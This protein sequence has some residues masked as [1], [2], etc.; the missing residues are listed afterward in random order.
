MAKPWRI[1]VALVLLFSLVSWTGVQAQPSGRLVLNTDLELLSIGEITG[2]G[3]LKWTLVGEQAQVLRGKILGMFDEQ[4]SIPRGFAFQFQSTGATGAALNNGQIES[5]EAGAY[6]SFL[7]NEMEGTQR[8]YAGVEFRFVQV[9]ATDRAE[10]DLPAERS[11]QGLVG[12]TAASTSN[13]EMSFLMEILTSRTPERRFPQA[14]R[15]YADSLHRVFS[16]DTGAEVLTVTGC[17][18]VCYPFPERNGWRVVRWSPYLAGGPF[19]WHGNASI[20]DPWNTTAS[21]YE[22]GW[23]NAT[24]YS[25]DGVVLSPIDLRF[26]TTANFSFEHTGGTA[27]GDSLIVELSTD[28]TSWQPLTAEGDGDRQPPVDSLNLTV[29]GRS[30]YNL[31]AWLGQPRVNLRLNFTANA[32]ATVG[33]SGFFVRNL[34]I[35]APSFFEGTIDLQHVDY[36]VGFLSFSHF[37]S[38]RVKPHVIRTPV[39]VVQYY[40][41]TYEADA[42][43]RDSAR[44]ATFDVIENAQILFVLLVVCAWLL[45]LFQDKA[46]ERYR[47]MHPVVLRPSAVKTK[48]L[49]WLGRVLI[50][51]F[52]LFYFFPTM[53]GSDLMVGGGA[54]WIMTISATVGT[55]LFT[56]FWYRRKESMLPAEVK[57]APGERLASELP[58]PPPPA[59]PE[60]AVRTICAH[61]DLDIED[62]ADVYVCACGQKY[63]TAH[64]AE[65]G[66]CVNCG[67]ELAPPPPPEK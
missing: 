42:I 22:P 18:P 64:A 37:D 45:G 27:S 39:G 63:H 51:L 58:P 49:H 11:S 38:P 46:W 60:G 14:T 28:G 9:K 65:R 53:L 8:N 13:M 7:E 35:E 31:T 2:G 54:Y 67:R 59:G 62:P 41:G 36:V 19:L 30:V 25:S 24:H 21:V 56:T 43:P 6:L 4:T 16:F 55:V 50:L 61:C 34:R 29:L 17:P 23:S 3:R 66:T 48:W 10:R 12:T 52:V 15:A 47:Q 5:A 26:A 20:P 40:Y 44:Y 33:G 1:F 32:D 57:L